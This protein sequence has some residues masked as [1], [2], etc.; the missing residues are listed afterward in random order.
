MTVKFL[1]NGSLSIISALGKSTSSLS[2][3]LSSYEAAIERV[4][5]LSSSRFVFFYSLFRDE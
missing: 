2:T 1:Y 3:R 4:A 5:L